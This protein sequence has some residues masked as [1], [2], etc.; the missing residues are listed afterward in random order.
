MLFIFLS[1]LVHAESPDIGSIISAE[2]EP[3]ALVANKVNAITGK[4]HPVE[5]DLII[6]GVEPITIQRVFVGGNKEWVLFSSISIEKA[7]SH[8]AGHSYI[9]TES[10]GSQIRYQF[11]D[12]KKMIGSERY[13]KYI[14]VDL[15][16]GYTNTSRGVISSRSNLHNQTLWV[17]PEEKHLILY[18]SDGRVRTYRRVNSSFYHLTEEQLPNGNWILYEYR[19]HKKN[20]QLASIRTTNS[21]RNIVYTQADFSYEYNKHEILKT[22]RITGSDGQT[23]KY[24]Y[25]ER[26]I[27]SV[28]SSIHPDES[29]GYFN[30]DYPFYFSKA[31]KSISLPSNRIL[32]ANYYNFN[33]PTVNG[34]KVELKHI[35]YEFQFNGEIYD[36]LMPDPR[37]GR[38]MTLSSSTGSNPN[39]QPTH[40]FFYELNENKTSVFDIENRRTDYHWD[41]H[42]RLNQIARYCKEGKLENISRFSWSQEGNLLYKSLLDGNQNPIWLKEYVYNRLGDI[43]EERIYG[44]LSGRSAPLVLNSENKPVAN[45]VESYCRRFSYIIENE[46]SRLQS[47]AEDQG[48]RVEYTYLNESDLITS[49]FA[50]DGDLLKERKFWEYDENRLLVREI[51]EDGKTRLI[52]QITPKPEAPYQG[53]PWI[54][55]EK[56]GDQGIERLIRKAVLHYTTGGRISQ[57]DISDSAGAFRYS[58]Q[59]KYDEKGRL[60]EETDPIGR[61][62]QFSYDSCGNRI[63]HKKSSGRT[64]STFTYDH[65]NLL[66]SSHQLGDDGVFLHE[67]YRYDR[68]NRLIF[69]EKPLGHQATYTYNSS[70]LVAEKNFPLLGHKVSYIYDFLGRPIEEIDPEGHTTKTAYNAS[71][72][73]IRIEHPDGGV[74]EF[75][76]Y[77]NGKLKTATDPLGLETS[78]TYDWQGRQISKTLSINK[79]VLH[80]ELSEYD[81]FHLIKKTDAEGNQTV[82]RYNLAGQLIATEMGEEKTEYVYDSLGRLFLEKKGGIQTIREYDLVDR[83]IEERQE[84]EKQEI[85]HRVQYSYDTADNQISMTRWIQGEESKETIVYDSIGRPIQKRDPLGNTSQIIYEQKPLLKETA[86]DPLG[87]KTVKTYNSQ[88]KVTTLEI[89]SSDGILLD[90][91]EFFYDFRGNLTQQ[92]SQIF[93]PSRLTSVTWTYDCMGRLATQTEG[94]LNPKITQHSYNKKGELIQTIKPD[95][96]T[97][98]YSYEPLGFLSSLTSSDHSISYTY[99]HDRLGRQLSSLDL[100]TGQKTEKRYD[101]QGRLIQEVLGTGYKLRNHYDSEGRRVRLTLPDTSFISYDYGPLHISR[102]SR[103]NTSQKL[104]YSHTFDAYDESGHLLKETLIG[105]LGVSHSDYDLLGRKKGFSSPYLSHKILERDQVG[106]ILKT[107]LNGLETEYRYDGLYQLASENGMFSHNYLNDAHYCH[108][109]KD[110]KKYEINDLLQIEDLKYDSN[111]NP[112][113]ES[114]FSYTYDALDRLIRVETPSQQISYTYDSDHRRLSKIIQKNGNSFQYDF[115]YDGENEIGTIHP[116][117]LI[118][119]LRV[120]G[121]AARSEIGAAIA[122][123]LQGKVYAPIHD[124]NGNVLLLVSLESKK[125]EITH[126]YSAFCEEGTSRPSPNPWRFSSKRADEETG[127]IYY[128]RRYYSPSLSRWLTPDPAGFTLGLNLYTFSK[129]NPLL[130]LDFFGLYHSDRASDIHYFDPYHTETSSFYLNTVGDRDLGTIDY[131]CGINNCGSDVES[132]IASLYATLDESYA[133]TGHWIHDNSLARGLSLVGSEKLCGRRS[134]KTLMPGMALLAAVNLKCSY[135]EDVIEYEFKYISEKADKILKEGNPNL[136]QVHVSFSNAS[137]SLSKALERLS[138]EQRSTVVLISVGPTK[139]IENDLAH[140]VYNVIGNKDYPSKLCNGYFKSV[141][142]RENANVRFIP[143]EQTK[144]FVFG[145]YFEQPDYQSM[146]ELII[147]KEISGD[148]EIY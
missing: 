91:Q 120:L 12:Q 74:E 33:S 3:S 128:G 13:R 67:E 36:R 68:K 29:F 1:I 35:P 81:N 96:V 60:I 61:V 71:N 44:N 21:A 87:L 42:F 117:G 146:V 113:G 46:I 122:M 130:Y 25:N 115:L 90:H 66:T 136:K 45:G 127:L 50:Y 48:K 56:Y 100:N 43:I 62:E 9:V 101:P 85:V 32:E 72:Q 20:Y 8:R 30:F 124:L 105:D 70:G 15:N 78:Y 39:P 102:V 24:N 86:I 75:V 27:S 123:E 89:F 18:C 109:E 125:P 147:S 37:S 134:I 106:N 144:P 52:R 107:D 63:S 10:T 133:I 119:E 104:V 73:P 34:K 26:S 98:S 141:I 11:T 76:Y 132:A 114:D 111:G 69:E 118:I 4:W 142:E 31:L 145:H 139:I 28:V 121:R 38:V 148:Y 64:S 58:L 23:V 79:Q 84:D 88:R 92:R 94:T 19:K 140:H 7:S 138:A 112:L 97:L 99:S 143:Q 110:E 47:A 14:P 17:G 93:A 126:H 57:K 80:E 49:Q 53:M 51:T 82:Y 6:Q 41:D 137:Y 77:L 5:N 129:N 65:S 16:K 108:L 40:F 83:L 54:I 55:E 131:H 103:Y 59:Y 135:I 116:S 2:N 95:G 22:C